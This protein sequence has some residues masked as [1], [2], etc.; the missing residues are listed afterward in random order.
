MSHAT[1]SSLLV[2]AVLS[3]ASASCSRIRE[4]AGHDAADD[5]SS[6]APHAEATAPASPPAF[7]G[8]EGFGAATRGGRGGRACHVKTLAHAGAGSLQACLDASGP[9]IVVFDVSGVI[10]GPLEVKHGRLTIAG[11]TAPGGIT[12]KGGLVCDNVYDPNDCNDLV[13][14]HV[15]FRG[16]APDSLRL[17]GAHDVIVDHCSMA[18]AE[19]E[20][21]ELT[22]SRNVTIQSSILAEPTGDHYPWGGLLINY[23]KDVLPLDRI[24]I[25]HTVWNGV[26]GRLPEIS[27][28]EN[29]DGP[30][31]SNCAGHVL[32]IE[33]ANN[34]LWDASDPIWFNHCTGN[35]EGNDCPTATKTF[36]LSLNLV[37]N[38]MVRRASADA[39]APLVEPAVYTHRGG[40]VHSADNLLLRGTAAAPANGSGKSAPRHPFPAVTYTPASAVVALLA[41]TAGPWPRDRMDER[42]ASYLVKPI[43]ARPAAWRNGRG[44]DAGDAIP[45]AGPSPAPPLDS[46]GDGM[47][48]AWETAHGL[49][50]RTADGAALGRAKGCNA[51]YAALE[52]YV[53]ELADARVPR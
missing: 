25:H 6:V 19:D 49:D 30:G 2:L 20:N 10:E 33:L 8:A 28:E 45:A 36:A 35:N 17:G 5:P 3:V 50:P 1:R 22:R 38:V 32:N 26:A 16:G 53:N 34:V 18:A 9:R 29:G 31:K 51:G 44:V 15:R 40:S 46:D 24:T 21:L 41:R 23:S 7:P 11:Q 47:P 43:D 48:D 14:R 37:G 12:V 13:V 39:D 42:L 27:C 4:L 52:C